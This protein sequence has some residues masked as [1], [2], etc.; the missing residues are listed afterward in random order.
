MQPVALKL[1]LQFA[2]TQ[3]LLRL[4]TVFWLP[5]AAIPQLNRATS[6]L[7]FGDRSLEVAIRER[8]IFDLHGQAL[9]MRIERRA[10]GHRP[11]FEDAVELET[12][13]VMQSGRGVFLDHIPPPI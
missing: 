1:K 13:I 7:P 12:K 8:V 9:V 3:G 10:L 4:E 2:I 5:V 6:I 11:G